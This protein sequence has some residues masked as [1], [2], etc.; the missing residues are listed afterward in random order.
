[1]RLIVGIG[2]GDAR[3]Q[4]LIAFAGQQIAVAQRF[5]AELGQ[6]IIA[7]RIRHHIKPAHV[8]RLRIGACLGLGLGNFLFRLRL[9]HL[10]GFSLCLFCFEHVRHIAFSGLPASIPEIHVTLCSPIWC[11]FSPRLNIGPDC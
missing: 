8:D 5:L 3:E 9:L 7:A 10:R 11:R 4:I 1:M 6:E 2:R